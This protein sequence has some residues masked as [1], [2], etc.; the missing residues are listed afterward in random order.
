MSGSSG[1]SGNKPNVGT[2]FGE[3]FLQ[4]IGLHDCEAWLDKSKPQR[5]D[6][7]KGD[8]EFLGEAGRL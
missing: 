3:I 5:L 4:R 8:L 7:R 2:A 6:H 1:Q